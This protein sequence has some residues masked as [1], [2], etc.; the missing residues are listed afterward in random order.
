MVNQLQTELKQKAE[1][2][3][4]EEMIFQLCQHVEEFLH[5]HN[6]PASKSFYDE[7][8]QR[9]KEKEEKDLLEESKQV[10]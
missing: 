9:Q 8:L 3:Q 10:E 7:M 2:L 5:R 4:G 1:C 6:K